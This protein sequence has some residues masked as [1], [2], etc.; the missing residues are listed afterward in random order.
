MKFVPKAVTRGVGKIVLSSKRNS[1]HIF[2]GTG[3]V[4]VCAGTVLA[5]RA[6][7]KLEP[8][9]DGI[10]G[11]IDL[12]KSSNSD[13]A[14]NQNYGKDLTFAYIRGAKDLGKLYGPSVIVGG[15]S[16]GLLTKSHIQLSKRNAVLT[17]LYT[18]AVQALEEYRERVRAE[19]GE[20]K[21]SDLWLGV[22]EETIV[23]EDGK[24]EKVKVINGPPGQFDRFFDRNCGNWK[25][26]PDYNRF[27]LTSQQNYHNQ[28][29]QATGY[30]FLNDIYEALG[31]DKVPEGQLVGW[32]LDAPG[33]DWI[34]F[35]LDDHLN[36]KN[37]DTLGWSQL[38]T[39]NVNPVIIYDKI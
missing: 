29:L 6:T 19:V 4:G 5:C 22:K 27:F 16:I 13:D 7:L 26:D 10:K 3:L 39:F 2:F 36:V 15:I 38:L 11:D 35:G 30:V 14:A 9:L 17:T 37:R 25:P 32:S 34:S 24:K 1:P 8:V 23:G 28:K 18:G 21:E 12:V 33:D 31:F 20:E